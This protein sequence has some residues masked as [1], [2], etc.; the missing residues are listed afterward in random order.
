LEGNKDEFD[1][2][3]TGWEP[4]SLIGGQNAKWIWI[5]KPKIGGT[6]SL[7]MKLRPVVKVEQRSGKIQLNRPTIVPFQSTVDVGVPADEILADRATRTKTVLDS[8]S[9]MVKAL[10]G[11]LVL[12]QSFAVVGECCGYD[13][14]A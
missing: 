2:Q 4:R 11:L 10:L 12:L 3:P 13:P 9:G 7:V 1:I 8:L 6:L 5:V 14:A